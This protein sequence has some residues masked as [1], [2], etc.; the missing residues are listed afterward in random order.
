M[1]QKLTYL[2]GGAAILA[3]LI[4][5]VVAIASLGGDG[6]DSATSTAPRRA[7]RPTPPEDRPEPSEPQQ[8]RKAPGVGA[9]GRALSQAVD[10]RR[11]VRAPGFAAPIVAKGSLPAQAESL[12]RATAGSSLALAALRGTP[13]VIHMTSARCGPCRADARLV[14]SA[15]RRW[16]R[17]GV[18]FVGVSVGDSADAAR[19]FARDYDLTY[20][21]ARDGGRV[22]DAYGVTSLSETF[23]VSGAGAVVGQIKGSPSV[24]QLELGTAAVREGREFGTEEGSS[25]VPRR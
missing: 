10:Q 4:L 6:D 15:W 1:W 13:V 3:G 12:D 7:E 11:T 14:E 5:I 21:I 23:F 24:R 25:R 17:R 2:L 9:R 8:R 20:P 16:G 18:A 22:A 19:R